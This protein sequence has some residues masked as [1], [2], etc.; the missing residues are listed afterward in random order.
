MGGAVTANRQVETWCVPHGIPVSATE[1]KLA[2]EGDSQKEQ[3]LKGQRGGSRNREDMY[4]SAAVG[5]A[6]SEAE[7]RGGKTGLF[8][9]S[10]SSISG[11]EKGK[12]P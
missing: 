1:G 3:E 10:S 11:T 6:T 4:L 2:R 9:V 7:M 8:T 5:S 12:Q